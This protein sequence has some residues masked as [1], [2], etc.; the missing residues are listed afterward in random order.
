MPGEVLIFAWL[1]SQKQ[2]NTCTIKGQSRKFPDY[3]TIS[4][5]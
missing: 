1:M 5:P 4:D 2:L 3:V